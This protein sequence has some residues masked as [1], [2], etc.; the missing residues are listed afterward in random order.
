MAE[1]L[2]FTKRYVGKRIYDE[3]VDFDYSYDLSIS[4]YSTLLLYLLEFD[5][6]VSELQ[7]SFYIA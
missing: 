5:W 3:L 7:W 4:G 1:M 2:I 6:N